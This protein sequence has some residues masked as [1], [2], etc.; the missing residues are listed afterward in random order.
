[1]K[2]LLINPYPYYAKGINTA[3][4]YPP[5]GLAYISSVL[6]S[7]N[8]ESKVI[9]ANMLKASNEKLIKI[10]SSQHQSLLVFQPT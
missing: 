10:I 1:M 6:E 9:D 5:I 7:N 8:F 2:A 4:I 3:S